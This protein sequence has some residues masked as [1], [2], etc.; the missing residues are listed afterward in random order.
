MNEYRDIIIKDGK[1]YI[2]TTHINNNCNHII[3]YLSVMDRI[4][5]FIRILLK[6][7]SITKQYKDENYLKN[8]QETDYL[9]NKNKLILINEL[10]VKRDVVTI[11]NDIIY[12]TNSYLIKLL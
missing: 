1:K 10:L 11:E 3:I 5:W 4:S 8:K 2:I 7:D 9:E 6:L 12:L